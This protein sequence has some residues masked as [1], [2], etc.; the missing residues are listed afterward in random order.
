VISVLNGGT[1][2]NA[3]NIPSVKPE[4]MRVLAPYINLAETIGRCM[5]PSYLEPVMRK[6]KSHIMER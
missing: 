1:A 6:W 4:V 3:I 5:V 2:K